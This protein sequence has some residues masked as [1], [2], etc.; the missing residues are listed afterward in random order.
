[1]ARGEASTS[2]PSYLPWS[3]R[4]SNASD[5]D[6]TLSSCAAPAAERLLSDVADRLAC[7]GQSS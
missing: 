2:F 5:A 6:P 7:T 1:M 3:G 4:L